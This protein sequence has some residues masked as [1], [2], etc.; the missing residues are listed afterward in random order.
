MTRRKP[1]T[2]TDIPAGKESWHPGL[3]PGPI[4]LIST[5]SSRGVSHAARKS[6]I[7][8]ASS[9]P[10]MLMLGCRLSHRTAINILE[11]R[12][13]VVNIPGDNLAARIQGAADSAQSSAEE[14]DSAA[15]TWGPSR[16]V[17]VPRVMECRA[18]IECT[19]ESTRRL[20]EEDLV[21]FATIETASVDASVLQG[22]PE[23]RYKALRSMLQLEEGLIAV[24]D[25]ATR[26]PG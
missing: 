17:A 21:F 24:I 6:W 3:L 19:L 1:D 9:R 22:A 5:L 11:T 20:N 4:V 15:W 23:N 25:H 26:L 18:H 2:K 7:S 13:F 10:P 12:E 14:D 16:K 8:M